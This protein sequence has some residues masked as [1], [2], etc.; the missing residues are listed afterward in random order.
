MTDS[1]G[2]HKHSM[3]SGFEMLLKGVVILNREIKVSILMPSLNVRPYIEEC[4]DSVVNQTL[5]EI[6]IIC[7]DAG[8]TD[9][10]IEIIEEYKRKDDRIK[11]IKSPIKSYGYQMNLGLDAALG[12]YIGIVETDDCI[13]ENMYEDLVRIAD[14]NDVDMLKAN[15]RRFYGDINNRRF[16]ER[17]MID[18][19]VVPYD[20]VVNPAEMLGVFKGNNVIWSGIYKTSFIRENGIR[21]NETP[22]ASYQDNGFWFITTCKAKRVMFISKDYYM[23]RRDNEN[24][25]IRSKDK[26]FCICDEYDYI[27]NR[28]LQDG[29]QKFL[30]LCAYRRFEGYEWTYKRIG[31]DHKEAFLNRFIEDF[32]FLSDNNE[33]NEELFSEEQL[34]SFRI[35][36]ESPLAYHE[37]RLKKDEIRQLKKELEKS[38]NRIGHLESSKAFKVGQIV[39]CLPKLVMRCFKHI[40]IGKD[41]QTR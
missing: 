35:V 32:K 24:S 41:N 36:M 22:G 2:S 3:S 37:L 10:T 19:E 5:K 11:I 1:T 27:R 8:S 23:V 7:I 16:N 30:P 38:E 20:T 4:L 39:T 9:G 13:R 14:E 17:A 28:L 33:I 31:E 18:P 26:V 40:S 6:E 29:M 25:S 15:F 12:T 34:K 21:F